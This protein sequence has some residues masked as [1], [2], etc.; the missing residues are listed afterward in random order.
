MTARLDIS[1]LEVRVGGNAEPVLAGLDLTVRAGETVALVGESGSGKTM[2]A[3]AAMRLLPRGAVVA[4]G[5]VRFGGEDV[6]AM[7]GRR[8]NRF[9]GGDAAMI[10]QQ[11]LA[12]LDPTASVGSQVAEAVRI[13]TGLTG[14]AV[15]KRVIELLREVGIPAPELRARA[16]AHQLSGGMAQRVMIA[17][18]LAGDPKLLIADEPTTALDVT[19]QLQILH[20]LARERRHR[21]LGILL[22]THDLSVVAALADR[23]IVLYAGRVV[24][25]GATA[26]LLRAP[27][28][29]Y[30]RALVRAS[31][32]RGEVDGRLFALAVG[33]R[34]PASGCRFLPRCPTADA[35]GLHDHCGG[36]EPPLDSA[37]DGHRVRCCAPDGAALVTGAGAMAR[38]RQPVTGAS[39]LTLRGVTKHYRV[40]STRVVRSVDSVD[41]DITTGEVVGLVGESGCGK[42]TLARLLLRISAPTGGRIV[43]LGQDQSTTDGA[44]LR[45]FR[46]DVQLVF[47]DPLA[48]LDPRMRIGESLR[49]PLDQNGIGLATER[50]VRVRAMM[51]EVGLAEDLLGRRPAECSGGQ[52]Q[53]VV[54][55]RALLLDPRILVCDEPTSALDASIRAQILNLLEDLRRARGLTMLMISHDLR[56]MRRLA[57]RV[58]VMYLGEI[59][60]IAE[61]E[62]LFR[63]PAHPYTRAL[64]DAALLGDTALDPDLFA[65]RGE[66]PSPLAPP[67]GCRF[68]PRCPSASVTCKR[69]HP[70][71]ERLAGGREVRCWHPLPLDVWETT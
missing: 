46:R 61:T 15:Q 18:A 59:V 35:Q 67:P 31:L 12:M 16:Y 50:D 4:K 32:L 5:M 26:E 17:A 44:A 3:L 42:S 22:I 38:P 41:L 7:P 56:V 60:E 53:R 66:P 36:H 37:A 34:R 33:D 51:R 45:A 40:D 27:R 63:S 14:S 28:H 64:L 8:L 58:A 19:V 21:G 43:A 71:F 10:F 52:L 49:A 48:A 29:P 20:L 9:R 2:T 13:H 70:A 69:D 65:V 25:E 47:Q 39:A 6:L 30:T 24:E 57:D 23:A 11:P 62:A 1:G 54:I 55:A 68:A